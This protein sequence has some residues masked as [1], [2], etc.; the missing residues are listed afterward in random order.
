MPFIVRRLVFYLVAAWVAIT[1]NFFIPRVMPGNAIDTMMSKFP[2]LPPSA[3]KALEA[4]FGVGHQGSLLHQY[5][6]YLVDLLHGN[7]GLSVDLSTSTPRA[8]RPSSARP[9]PGR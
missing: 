5:W 6:T 9:S 2:M 3:Q 8:S 7:L 4:E 1:V